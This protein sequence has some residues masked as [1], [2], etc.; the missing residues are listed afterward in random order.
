M[1]CP[2]EVL[3]CYSPVFRAKCF[4]ML[5]PCVVLLCLV[6]VV[7]VCKICVDGSSALLSAGEEVLK[8]SPSVLGENHKQNHAC[9]TE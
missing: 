2:L 6:Y 3:L 8:K 7:S 4:C 5:C 1:L 9:V